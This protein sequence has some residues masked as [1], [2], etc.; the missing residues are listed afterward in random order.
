[1]KNICKIIIFILILMN[2]FAV[3]CLADTTFG[4][5]LIS[6]SEKI[7]K[8]QSEVVLYLSLQDYTKD[9][10]LGYEASIEYDNTVFESIVMEGLNGWD[11]PD[12]D[13]TTHKF[14]ST[15]KTA[16]ANTNIAKITMKVKKNA[17]EKQTEIKIKNLI[18][19][20]GI[21]SNTLNLQKSF[22]LVANQTNNS[23]N[24]DNKENDNTKD[25]FNKDDQKD[26]QKKDQK[27]DQKNNQTNLD[28]ENKEDSKKNENT[29]TI[30]PEDKE[31]N[32][33]TTAIG[34]IPQTGGKPVII[35]ILSI[36]VIGIICYIRYRS[37]QIK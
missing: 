30:T 11:T 21:D 23:T 10:I 36:G 31:K 16:K 25:D 9:G 6:G 28:N 4:I 13:E 29:I 2:I 20:D 1:M 34:K 18:I 22:S 24:E 14:V 19:S 8:D 5:K 26:N 33:G 35:A 7:L 27:N 3:Y 15:T 12:Y 17:T 37:I 32:D